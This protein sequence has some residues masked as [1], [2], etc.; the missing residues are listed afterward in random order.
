MRRLPAALILGFY[1]MTGGLVHAAE[2]LHQQI[3]WGSVTLSA[4]QKDAMRK[5]DAMWQRAFEQLYPEIQT[6]RRRLHRLLMEKDTDHEAIFQ[7]LRHLEDKEQELRYEAVK[8]FLQK[9]QELTPTQRE[10]LQQ[11]QN[12][13]TPQG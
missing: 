8:N 6:E 3:N 7:A 4:S 5:H 11:S 10:K 1:S 13:P 12:L 9:K 2:P